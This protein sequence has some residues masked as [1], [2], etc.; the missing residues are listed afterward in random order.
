MTDLSRKVTWPSSVLLVLIIVVCSVILLSCGKEE[1]SS[2]SSPQVST[3]SS[4]IT[5]P[6]KQT[7][8]DNLPQLP[9]Q[10][11][12]D[13]GLVVSWVQ[14]SESKFE[15]CG[16]VAGM[17]GGLLRRAPLQSRIPAERLLIVEGGGWS[18]GKQDFQLI[19]SQHYIT[20]LAAHDIAGL[21][22]GQA[23]LALGRDKLTS[24]VEIANE[25]QLAVLACNVDGLPGLKPYRL[26]NKAGQDVLLTAIAPVMDRVSELA[27]TDPIP[28]LQ[29]LVAQYPQHHIIVMADQSVDALR[30]LAQQVPGLAAI[31]GGD[32]HDP[33][34]EVERIG[35]TAVVYCG[36]HG[37]TVAWWPLNSDVIAFELLRDSYPESV[38]IRARIVRY[39]EA[40]AKAELSIDA[41]QASGMVR[42]G[43]SKATYVGSDT[44]TVCHSDAAAIH[45]GSRHHHAWD[46]LQQKGY[47]RD[48]ECLLCHVTGLGEPSGFTRLQAPISLRQVG[49]ESCH[50]PGSGH[51]AAPTE[52]A[53]RPVT[54]STCVQCHDAENSPHFEFISYWQKIQ[55][56]KNK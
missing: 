46:T 50:G 45:G 22:V 49:C 33:S 43:Q 20:A 15:P 6:V 14:H 44:C 55:H 53:L 48:P 30:H 21:A 28:H 34:S 54:E 10:V 38:D 32:V 24:L 26:I 39:Q 17:F 51:V 11:D 42:L 27:V 7:S 5:N 18:A 52:Q 35:Q 8:Y 12:E 2:S 37:K 1:A 9:A 19:K 16:C 31:I 29:A 4:Q 3:T 25:Q 36:N 23:E 47:H 40:L 56:G 41:P 13:S